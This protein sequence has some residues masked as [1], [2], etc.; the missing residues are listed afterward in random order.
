MAEAV[1]A[2]A[3]R[4][5]PRRR[6]RAAPGSSRAPSLRPAALPAG[7]PLVADEPRLAQLRQLL[8]DLLP[9]RRRQPGAVADE[10]ELAVLAVQPEEQRRDPALRLLAVAEP[11]DHAVGRLVLLDLGD[12]VA[13]ARQVGRVRASS[14]PRRRARPPRAGRASAPRPS[15]RG[16]TARAGSASPCA[17]APCAASRAGACAASRPSRAG[18]RRR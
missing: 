13:R 3:C 4:S 8:L 9:H 15:G 11:D 14:R 10:V 1:A 18:C 16:C 17:R 5:A 12:A 7:D 2:R 6:A